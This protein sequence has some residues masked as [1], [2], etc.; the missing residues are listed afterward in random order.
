MRQVEFASHVL[1]GL[2]KA[3]SRFHGNHHQIES[4]RQREAQ[5]L[6]PRRDPL[7][8]E[9]HRQTKSHDG[10]HTQE[11]HAQRRIFFRQILQQQGTQ[12]E[13]DRSYYA[14][15]EKDLHGLLAAIAGHD[16]VFTEL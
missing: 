8:K 2:I 14:K 15:S 5:S 9:E 10:A 3:E 13:G 6:L 12:H 4:V 7:L 1:H 11:H 16:Q